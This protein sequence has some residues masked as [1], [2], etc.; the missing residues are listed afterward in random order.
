M[1]ELSKKL[2]SAVSKTVIKYGLIKPDDKIVVGLSGG[3]DSFTLLHLL[4]R[5]KRVAPY[6]FE[7]LAVTIDYTDMGD[8]SHIEKH[9]AEHRIPYHIERTNILQRSEETIRENSS[10]CSYFSR[11]RR[12][13]LYGVCK[14]KG[15]NKLAL[16]HHLDDAAESFFMNMFNNGKLRSM[17]P[18]YKTEDGELE[19]IRPMIQIREH[20]TRECAKLNEF[21]IL[22]EVCPAF[23]KPTKPPVERENIKK[24]LK[25]LETDRKDLFDKLRTSFS[26]IQTESFSD[27]NFLK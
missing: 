21:P 24:L 16:G 26:N 11:M 3:K 23:L 20:K 22:D 25:E 5:I 10:F 27:L 17:A 8:Y 1:V 14:E 13:N 6:D 18:I 19:V 2:T 15:Y 4:N 9:L 7:I 12:G